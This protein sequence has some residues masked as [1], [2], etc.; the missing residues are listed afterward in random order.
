MATTVRRIKQE[1]KSRRSQFINSREL[2][3]SLIAV[4]QVYIVCY[5]GFQES[6][7]FIPHK[8]GVKLDVA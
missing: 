2:F 8:I 3:Y 6:L 4:A 7:E 5:E 1:V